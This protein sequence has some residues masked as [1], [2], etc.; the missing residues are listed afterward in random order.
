MKANEAK[1]RYTKS[2]IVVE[3]CPICGKTYVPAPLHVYKMP[4]RNTRVCSYHCSME[5]ERR[6]EAGKKKP[7]RRKNNV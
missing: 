2:Q 5:A 3:T 4:Y 1:R 7:G 6:Y